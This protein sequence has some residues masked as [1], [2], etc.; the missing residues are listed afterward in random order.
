MIMAA[1]L[2][3]LPNLMRKLTIQVPG[4]DVEAEYNKRLKDISKKANI[5]GFRPGK[6]PIKVIDRKYGESIRNE[7]IPEI[8]NKELSTAIENE[9]LRLVGN[10]AITEIKADRGQ[11]IEFSAEFEIL[12]EFDLNELTGIEIEKVSSEVA[13]EDIDKQ[14]ETLREEHKEWKEV[15]RT[16]KEQ[17]LVTLTY[18]AFKVG[19]PFKF[20]SQSDD[21]EISQMSVVLGSHTMPEAFEKALEGVKA[22]ENKTLTATYPEDH[23]RK[24]LAGAKIEFKAIIKRVS[25]AE[26]P[27]ITD[28]FANELGFE[29]GVTQ[30]RQEVRQALS[31]NLEKAFNFINQ[32]AIFDK[33]IEENSEIQLPETLVSQEVNYLLKQYEQATTVTDLSDEDKTELNE[34]AAKRVK[35]GLLIGQYANAHDMKADDEKVRQEVEQVASRYHNPNE[36]AAWFYEDESRLNQIK[37]KILEGQVAES[38][39]KSATIIEKKLSYNETLEA[40]QKI[41]EQ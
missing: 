39:F 37:S 3:A 7:M 41:L 6:V 2:E 32:Q 21:D 26:L 9:K 10:P 16:A 29:E 15:S 23:A 13:D 36:I 5:D 14:L 28:Q 17:D 1:T 25:E 30:L 35:L 31:A 22:A 24:D 33:F 40:Q 38:L 20:D 11:D 27:E 8:V 4:Q 18:E 19:E 12:P 34:A